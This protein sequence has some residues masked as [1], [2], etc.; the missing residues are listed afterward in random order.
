MVSVGT[1]SITANAARGAPTLDACASRNRYAAACRPRGSRAI[2]GYGR[3]WLEALLAVQII[4]A[5]F[6][7]SLAGP[8]T[9]VHQ[10]GGMVAR[11]AGLCLMGELGGQQS[12]PT[13][14]SPATAGCGWMVSTTAVP[15]MVAAMMANARSETAI[16]FM[17]E[18][19][20]L[21]GPSGADF[22]AR[23]DGQHET[24]LFD[25]PG[26]HANLR[27]LPSRGPNRSL[28]CDLPFA[29]VAR[30]HP[31]AF[32]SGSRWPWRQQR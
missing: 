19:S 4:A 8:R 28:M 31:I 32:L 25:R 29:P 24:S 21:T 1:R 13:H 5:G 18:Y 17:A 2:A 12:R 15:M 26:R 14:G 9:S 23:C 27:K 20:E 22:R 30:E 6:S 10:T 16:T 7:I 3:Q 11:C